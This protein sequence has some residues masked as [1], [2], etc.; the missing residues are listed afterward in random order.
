EIADRSAK[1]YYKLRLYVDDMQ[2]LGNSNQKAQSVYLLAMKKLTEGRGN[3]NTQ[4]EGFKSLGV[5]R[6]KTKDKD[7]VE[8][9]A[10][11]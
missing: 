11:D 6:K 9:S 5:E 8:K 3:H 1:M 10:S 7:L 4:P 2:G